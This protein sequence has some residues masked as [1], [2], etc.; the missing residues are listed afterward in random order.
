MNRVEKQLFMIC[1]AVALLF[2]YFLYDDSLLFPPEN[3][4][5]QKLVGQMKTYSNDV[6]RKSLE[7]FLWRPVIKEQ[8][9]YQKDSLFTGDSSQAEI[10]LYDGS[11]L[12]I[13]ENTLITLNFDQGQLELD[14]KYGDLSTRLSK[15]SQIQI[16]S[17]EEKIQLDTSSK[18]DIDIKKP[19]SQKIKLS[20]LNG[21]ADVKSKNQKL[22][23]IKNQAVQLK[24]S[25]LKV[26]AEVKSEIRLL[27]PDKSRFFIQDEKQGFKVSW[28]STGVESHRVLISTTPD[29]ANSAYTQETSS[30]NQVVTAPLSTGSYYWKVIGLDDAKQD[31]ATSPTYRFEIVKV[32]RPQ[33]ITPAAQAQFEYEFYP[34]QKNRSA[35]TDFEWNAEQNY[36]IYE[37]QVSEEKDFKQ[38]AYRGTTKEK[39]INS[40]QLLDRQYFVRVRGITTDQKSSLWSEPRE[41]KISFKVKEK[42]TLPPP[43]LVTK[44]VFFDPVKST[45]NPASL[46]APQIL[47][48]K[49]V[50]ASA[51]E[52]EVSKNKDFKGAAK[53]VIKDPQF[54]WSKYKPGQYYFRVSNL[55]PENIRSEPS[56]VGDLEIKYSDLVL[57][58]VKDV[59]EFS[60]DAKAEA[61]PKEVSLSWSPV[62]LSSGY[63]V[64]LDENENFKAPQKRQV[65]SVPSKISLD[66]P[67]T[68]YVRVIALSDNM[69]PLTGYSNTEKLNYE[70]KKPL[71]APE[72]AQPKNDMT[73]FLQQDIEPF[74]WL[75]WNLMEKASSYDLEIS[76]TP[77]FKD[78]IVR[79]NLKEN[80][81]LIK[82]KI[83]L[84]EIYWRVKARHAENALNSKWSEPRV[85]HL[86]HKKN[87]N[88]FQ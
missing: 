67:G 43:I 38:L 3:S 13:K 26:A 22:S 64:E 79:T 78:V 18:S 83:P 1:A 31:I 8:N 54:V 87:E 56:E 35:Q 69:K 41:F 6:R 10:T 40:P 52:V 62:P 55:G 12:Q 61:P 51:Y 73:V 49:E 60:D 76:S 39:R 27:V 85:F 21:Q 46:K 75:N 19:R 44:K 29:F 7:S 34:S 74:L 28:T 58:K 9:L 63:I 42:G 15:K 45:R 16:R 71:I 30:F 36:V 50:L 23:L 2:T 33:V 77:T 86:L 68:Y 37:W 25:V 65:S 84:G 32:D 48:K 4:S 66:K 14:L 20:L 5:H 11:V 81:F 70:F 53:T 59:V 72:L 57:D 47:W 88:N 17:G 82:D 80:R 24:S